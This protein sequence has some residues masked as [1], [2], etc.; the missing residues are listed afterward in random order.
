MRFGR[1]RN[2]E[3]L[4]SFTR[5]SN[6][7]YSFYPNTLYSQ[8][9]F[10]YPFL[11]HLLSLSASLSIYFTISLLLSLSLSFSKVVLSLK[12][13]APTQVHRKIKAGCLCIRRHVTLLI[14]PKGGKWKKNT[15]EKVTIWYRNRILKMFIN[16][17]YIEYY[18]C[19]HHH[20][21]TLFSTL[22]L[23][24]FF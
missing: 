20:H 9:S 6:Y 23:I 1:N 4:L 7:H 16:V 19:R 15:K 13:Y 5:G 14:A 10:Y 17:I 11:S 8:V 3:S 2:K 21:L 24:L 22:F 12:S 18:Y